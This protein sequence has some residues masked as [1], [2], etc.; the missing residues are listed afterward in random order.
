MPINKLRS[1]LPSNKQNHQK[2]KIP[3]FTSL[4]GHYDVV[5]HI[6][7]PKT[8]S[9]AIQKFLLHNRK[10]LIHAGYYYPDHGLDENG[11]SG[12]Q[13]ILG[14]KLIDGELEAA[15][16]I[17]ETYINEAKQQNCILLISA[18]ALFNKF[19]PL[20]EMVGKNRCKI[21][22]FTRDPIESLYS[23][24]NQGI[25]R[26]YSTARLESYCKH[27]IDKPADFYTGAIFDKWSRVFG[28]ENI[29]I[30]GYDL[31][32][33]NEVPIQSV[34][35][36]SIGIDQ[37]VQKDYFK[38]DRNTINNSYYLAALE[39]KRMLNFILDQ[40]QYRLNNE[41][42]WFL[43]GISDK[44]KHPR[45]KLADR[46]SEDI[47]KQL[48]HKFTDTN[49]KIRKEYLTEINPDFL[50]EDKKEIKQQINQQAVNQDMSSI[51]EQLGKEKPE[52]FLY[53]KKQLQI[54]IEHSND[55]EVFK[56]AE[57]L[58][59]DINQITNND[60]WFNKNQLKQMEKWQTV[61]FLRDIAYQCYHRGDIEHASLLIEKAREI[62]PNGPAI[63]KLSDQI[64]IEMES[65][66]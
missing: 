41:I 20:K 30:L 15:K 54:V 60:F 12:G 47:Y 37:T 13:S 51:L 46:I 42:D 11:V 59:Y 17:L 39:L 25:K 48:K 52:I 50:L 36:L 29:T 18:E 63:I 9:S 3:T 24:Y 38:I 65:I 62:R 4:S 55:Y 66:K 16:A 56:L 31:K 53:I 57:M 7:A 8:G 19:E 5:I 26:H 44:S 58:N 21:I 10:G 33:F 32:V 61:D 49:K 40:E 34:F 35:L 45:Y 1:L 64:K 23:N 43:Q 28:K 22:A 14:K 2:I 6:G 27:L